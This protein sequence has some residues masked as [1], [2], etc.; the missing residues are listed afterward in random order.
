MF[1]LGITHP[2]S[3]NTATV[4][5]EDGKIIA[6]VEE[7]RF[8]RIKHAPRMIPS[9]SIDYV[10]KTAN[11]RYGDIE[12]IA[13]SWEGPHKE[14]E[15]E[16]AIKKGVESGSIE[17]IERKFWVESIEKEKSLRK[18]NKNSKKKFGL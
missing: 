9:N 15:L 8:L 6:A 3:W 17:N 18:I 13:I 11:I 5:L 1:I 10:L 7:E 2:I 16:F 12:K 14:S 4:L